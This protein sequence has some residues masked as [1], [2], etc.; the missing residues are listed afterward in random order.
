MS[1]DAVIVS[2]DFI[3]VLAVDGSDPAPYRISM[4][5]W[6]SLRLVISGLDPP[7]EKGRAR[8]NSNV[9]FDEATRGSDHFL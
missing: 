2:E 4:T 1:S 6:S 9:K 7:E 3:I 8:S 5:D